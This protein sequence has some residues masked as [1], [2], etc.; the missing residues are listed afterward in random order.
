MLETLQDL[1][2]RAL[3]QMAFWPDEDKRIARGEQPPKAQDGASHA[4]TLWHYQR[5]TPPTLQTS[6]TFP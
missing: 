6:P 5:N 3:R 1:T 2:D 4:E